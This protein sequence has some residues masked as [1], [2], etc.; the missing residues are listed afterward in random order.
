MKHLNI[1][2]LLLV[3]L[4]MMDIKVNASIIDGINYSINDENKTA[5]VVKSSY[6]RY[7]GHI[8]IPESIE[9]NG[10]KYDVTSIGVDAFKDCSGLTSLT[11]PSSVTSIGGSAFRKCSGL[12]SLTILSGVT[13]ID[14]CAFLDCSGLTSLTIPSSVRSIGRSAFYGC[15]GLTSLTIPNSV[16]SI[17]NQ[18]FKGCS[19]LTSITIPNSVTSIGNQAYSGCSGLTSITIPNSVTK[20]DE[21]AFY[22]CSGLTSLTIPSSVTSIGY[23]A[24]FMCSGLTS[25]TIPSSVTSIGKSAFSG[26]SGLT[27]LTIPKSVKAIYDNSFEDCTSLRDVYCHIESVPTTSASA[28]QGASLSTATLHVPTHALMDYKNIAPWSN[29]GNIV[30]L[31]GGEN[32]PT[33]K[34]CATP[35]ISYTKG[36]LSVKCSTKGAS[37]ITT[38]TDTDIKT[39]SGN[40]ID[41]TVTYDIKVYAT[42]AGYENSDMATATLCWIDSNPRTEGITNPIAKVEARPILIQSQNGVLTISSEGNTEP[43]PV[44]VYNTAGQMTGLTSLTGEMTSV[45]TNMNSGDIAIV[46]IGEKSIKM[47]VK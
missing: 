7:S 41:L 42:G 2:M 6:G 43:T 29:F 11:I 39:H 9:Y 22:G 23:E 4:S 13:R 8:S 40:E 47:V 26:C 14:E 15:S 46:K 44:R 16:T 33:V 28:F 45:N 25:L 30:A 34:K 32:P 17:G 36:K 31:S 19:G 10:E 1:T 38:I 37:C 3:L 5:S 12:T 27:S 18:A 35:S 21:S 20:I 24:F